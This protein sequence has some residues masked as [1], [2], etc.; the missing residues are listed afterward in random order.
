M[1]QSFIG[2]LK[3]GFVTQALLSLSHPMQQS[4]IESILPG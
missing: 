4:F 1:Q 3:A 2:S